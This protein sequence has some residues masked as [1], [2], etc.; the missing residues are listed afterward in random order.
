[1]LKLSSLG[2]V[3]PNTELFLRQKEGSLGGVKTGFMVRGKNPK[4]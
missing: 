4:L 3:V 1:M 2:A